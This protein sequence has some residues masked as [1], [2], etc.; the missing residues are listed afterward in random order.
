MRLHE[1]QDTTPPKGLN[2]TGV[3]KNFSFESSKL[4]HF[5]TN[6]RSAVLVER[7]LCSAQVFMQKI[8]QAYPVTGSVATAAAALLEG[9]IF[10]EAG[11]ARM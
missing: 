6:F 5:G 4:K 9:S 11:G 7:P 1:L 10:Q 2:F 8:H 3:F